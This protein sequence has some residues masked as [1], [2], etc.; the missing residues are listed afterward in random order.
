M[1]LLYVEDNEKLALNTS[2]SLTKSGFAVDVVHTGADALHSVA[3]YEYDAIIL[4]LGLPDTEGLTV[5]SE[6]KRKAA[7]IPVIICTARDATD[8]RVA[9]LNSGSD[10]YIV[11]PFAVAELIARIKAVLRRPGGA[12]G[13]NLDAGNIQFD[14]IDRTVRIN[15]ETARF[16]KRELALLELFMRRKGRVL[17]K[18]SIENAL[19]GFDEPPTLNAIEVAAHRLRKK[20]VDFGATPKIINLRGIGYFLEEGSA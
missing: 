9:G 5:L 12:L 8:D 20:L 18:D 6:V 7:Q 10:D 3:S 19:Y 13:L 15:G 14:T 2:A 11:K 4:D 1:R 16:S 17:S